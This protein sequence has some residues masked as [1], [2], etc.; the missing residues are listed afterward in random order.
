MPNRENPEE[1][2][3]LV[4]WMAKMKTAA[5]RP[6]E[7]VSTWEHVPAKSPTVESSS[8]AP[9]TPVVEVYAQAPAQTQLTRTTS[10][11]GTTKLC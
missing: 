1:P 5:E 11:L 9:A 4:R 8:L 2:V 10:H 7:S 6:T 3:A